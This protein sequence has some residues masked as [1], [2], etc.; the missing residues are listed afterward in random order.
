MEDVH[1]RAGVCEL[2]ERV[3]GVDREPVRIR[4]E[5][6]R[7]VQEIVAAKAGASKPL[8]DPKREEEIPRREAGERGF[9]LR[10][11]DALELRVDPSP[12][13]RPRNAKSLPVGVDSIE[14]G[15]KTGAKTNNGP[16]QPDR[17]RRPALC[18][19]GQALPVEA[20]VGLRENLRSF[21]RAMG[22][23]VV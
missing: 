9:H 21:A 17:E 3:D 18:D 20:L 22:H 8:F 14:S 6:A 1:T 11:V 15:V 7:L 2:R 16:I 10:L 5:R 13:P 12:H 4:N 23:E 19:G